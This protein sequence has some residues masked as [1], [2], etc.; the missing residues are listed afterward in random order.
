MIDI[1]GGE[2]L[3]LE[4]LVL[5]VN[6]TLSDRG[7]LGRG[8][9]PRLRRLGAGLDVWLLSADTFGTLAGIA[10]S[11]GVGSRQVASG[12]EK[13][14]HLRELDATTCVAIGN[15]ANDRAMLEEAAL[16][17]AVLGPEGTS[18]AAIA[19]ADVVCRSIVEA[20]ELLLDDRALAATLRR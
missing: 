1:P 3:S 7:E 6:G 14:A 4:H 8:V 13:V 18:F 10:S 2:P 19:A 16:G 9:A 15:G 5:D 12:E 20:L 11:L 17:I